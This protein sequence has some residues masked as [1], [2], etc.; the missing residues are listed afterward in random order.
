M[1]KDKNVKCFTAAELKAKRAIV[2][3]V[4]EPD[5]PS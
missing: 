5:I 4:P 1:K 2:P 3:H